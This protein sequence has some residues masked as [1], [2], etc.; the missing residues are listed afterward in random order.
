MQC[1]NGSNN[2]WS[3]LFRMGLSAGQPLTQTR[4]RL[5]DTVTTARRLCSIARPNEIL[6]SSRIHEMC[7]VTELARGKASVRILTPREQEFISNL[8]SVS[9]EN[10]AD[11]RFTVDRLTRFIGM[12][13]P[14]LYRKV[15]SLTGKSP[16]DF[17]RDLRL[18]KAF[19]LLKQKAGN[20]SEIAMEVGYNNPSYF[21][22]CFQMRFGCTPSR[23]MS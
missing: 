3:I 9:E 13:R 11:E 5:P 18:D 8:F 17:I 1:R 21:A 12:S 16:H 19:T 7:D 15:V 14:Q 10:M 4:D 23:L 2:P 20:V 6:F 22:R